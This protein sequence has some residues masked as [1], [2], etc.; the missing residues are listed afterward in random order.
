MIDEVRC[1]YDNCDKVCQN[2]TKLADHRRA[3]HSAPADAKFE[4][5]C[6]ECSFVVRRR[7]KDQLKQ[8]I[9]SHSETHSEVKPWLCEYCSKQFRQRHH[10]VS[11]MNT[12]QGVFPYECVPCT[13]RYPSRELL[14]QHFRKGSQH[15]GAAASVAELFDTLAKV[16]ENLI[17]H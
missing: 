12:H 6:G 7:N 17:N 11:H 16:H 2:R 14:S 5:T 1:E 13:K 4:W 10:W 9:K 3:A 15:K 8:G